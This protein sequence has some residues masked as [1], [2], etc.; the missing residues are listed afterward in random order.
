MF[1]LCTKYNIQSQPTLDIFHNCKKKK[2]THNCEKKRT[3]LVMYYVHLLSYKKNEIIPPCPPKKKNK[4][5]KI[6]KQNQLLS[7]TKYHL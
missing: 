5:N 6:T 3:D 1:L 4:Q 7:G 2:R